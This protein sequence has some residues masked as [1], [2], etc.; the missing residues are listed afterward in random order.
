MIFKSSKPGSTPPIRTGPTRIYST[1]HEAQ[2]STT[3]Q[4]SPP[5]LAKTSARTSNPALRLPRACFRRAFQAVFRHARSRCASLAGSVPTA[6]RGGSRAG[7]LPQA[8]TSA[9]GRRPRGESASSRS[10]A[11]AARAA[12]RTPSA[13]A[14][15]PLSALSRVCTLLSCDYKDPL[16]DTA[17]SRLAVFSHLE[18]GSRRGRTCRSHAVGQPVL[19]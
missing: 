1:H 11:A 4:R 12:A 6:R 15:R 14:L 2:T 8:L 19:G 18:H 3:F 16:A 13:S 5:S 17:W 7:A 10:A 9:L